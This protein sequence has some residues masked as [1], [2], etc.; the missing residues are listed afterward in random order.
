M[1]V[2]ALWANA[3][4]SGQDSSRFRGP[5]GS[6]FYTDLSFNPASLSG[7]AKILWQA[8][9]NNGYCG[10]AI[11]ADKLYT[12]GSDFKNDIV[13]CLNAET[14]EVVW[15]FSYR[16]GPNDRPGPRATPA[17]DNGTVFTLSIEGHLF[18]LDAET[19]AVRWQ[20]NFKTDFGVLPPSSDL[21]SSV[22][23]VD[24][25]LLINANRSGIALDKNTGEKIWTSERDACGYATP[26]LFAMG[27]MK[28]AAFFGAEALYGVEL[29]TGRVIWQYPW[30]TDHYVNAPDPFIFGN[31]IFIST[32][33][34]RG[35]A[36]L[37]FNDSS[38]SLKWENKNLASQ[39]ST[40]VAL[41][42]HIYGITGDSGGTGAFRV[43]DAETGKAALEQP[44]KYGSFIVVNGKF[45]IISEQGE[46][47]VADVSPTSYTAVSS[48]SLKRNKYWTTPVESAGRLFIRNESGDL[49]CISMK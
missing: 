16:C 5:E 25:M 28:C 1:I 6:S 15:T 4:L 10:V 39:Y 30:L 46:L 37:E 47:S 3:L 20:K 11:K 29:A 26:V 7:G 33:Y 35:C 21:A 8:K 9:V 23:V 18:A 12:M 17:I 13:S 31:K 24:N 34:D 14:G 44:M 48:A 45:V 36:L 2:L 32:G 41:D 49:F 42:G 40:P 43:L 22:I 27:K 38:I 19:G